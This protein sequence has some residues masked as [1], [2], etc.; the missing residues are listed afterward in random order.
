MYF[1]CRERTHCEAVVRT[2]FPDKSLVE[3]L[4]AAIMKT[5]PFL[6]FDFISKPVDILSRHTS[7]VDRYLRHIP[8]YTSR[9]PTYDSDNL[10]ALRGVAGNL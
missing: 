2:E 7:E 1:A 6:K 5:G 8:E 10:N 9:T 4:D 3:V